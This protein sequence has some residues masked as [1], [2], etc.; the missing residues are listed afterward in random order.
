MSRKLRELRTKYGVSERSA[1]LVNRIDPTTNKKYIEWLFKVRYYKTTTDK[2]RVNTEFPASMESDVRS[3]LYWYEK[4]LNGKIPKELRDINKFKTITEFMT[5]IAEIATPSR[6]DIK[7]NVRVVLDNDRFKVIVPL[8]YESSKLYGSGTKWCTTQKS[9]Y[10]NYTSRGVLYYI[11]DKTLNRKFGLVINNTNGRSTPNENNFAFFNNE[12][13]S[14]N[15]RMIKMIYGDNFNPVILA[16]K[17][18]FVK[19]MKNMMKKVVLEKAVKNIRETK[20]ELTDYGL[21]DES[22][23]ELLER[24]F[25]AVN[26]KK[27][28]LI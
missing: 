25:N 17:T 15:V 13:A 27:S 20:N 1:S 23:N 7:N 19:C 6:A 16:I 18:D 5:K 11:V 2:Y 9:Y 28:N 10:K 3:A 14:V 21:N 26:G 8:S 22:V 12:D 4:N 24:L